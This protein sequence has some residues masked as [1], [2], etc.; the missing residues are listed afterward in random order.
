MKERYQQELSRVLTVFESVLITLSCVS[1]AS[2][3]FIIVP[4]LFAGFGTV[5]FISMCIASLI[6]VCMALCWAELGARYPVTGG[7]YCII[8]RAIGP[9]WG[10]SAFSLH[11]VLAPCFVPLFALGLGS[12]LKVVI[13]VDPTLLAVLATVA[14]ALTAILKVR[15]GAAITGAFLAVEL[16]ALAVVIYLGF[17][18]PERSIGDLLRPAVTGGTAAPATFS[19]IV[20]S[21]AL[22]VFT[23]AG[24]NVPTYL[25]EETA[26]SSGGVAR[27]VLWSVAAV[28][29]TTLI[30]ITAVLVGAKSIAE[31]GKAPDL[32]AFVIDHGGAALNVVLS[33]AVAG[34]IFNAM[35]AI[36]MVNARFLYS[37]GRDQA[38]PEPVGSWLARV[39]SSFRTPARAVIAIAAVQLGVIVS[40]D[41]VSLTT[42]ISVFFGIIYCM[43]A[44]AAIVTR[45]KDDAQPRPYRM[46]LW[47]LPPLLALISLTYVLAQQPAKDLWFTAITIA[48]ALG[49]YFLY[50]ARK[51]EQRWLLKGAPAAGASAL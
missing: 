30:P 8:S 9:A 17:A 2:A 24:F 23:Q 48:L 45:V 18:H 1:P 10:F 21:L 40:V 14:A 27:A 29:V 51:P 3:V 5:S 13:N 36:L 15:V 22:A 41:I 39:H 46:P 44:L 4:V 19:F 28:V 37:S 6:S 34:A 49:Y 42:F 20:T 11:L 7:D 43:I 38:W 26:G 25:S 12:Y 31:L 35:I 16:V 32:T 50:L 33:L 47:P